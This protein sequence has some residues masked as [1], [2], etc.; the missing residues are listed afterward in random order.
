MNRYLKALGLATMVAFAF[1]AVAAASASAG[2]TTGMLTSD[3]PV[4]LEGTED[5]AGTNAFTAFGQEVQCP[6][7]H[8]TGHKANVTPHERLQGGETEVTIT[9][10]YTNCEDGE[11]GERSVNPNGC[12]YEFYDFTTTGDQVGT[13]GTYGL[14]A[15]ID[16]GETGKEIEVSGGTCVVRVPEQTELTGLHATNKAGAITIQG[17][18]HSITA[19]TCLGLTTHEAELHQAV[20]VE[21]ENK[22]GEATTISISH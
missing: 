19:N 20:K 17:T 1:S 16:C 12:D 15:H 7:S 18:I 6:E 4:T 9:P 11:G 21:G 10:E 8:Y 2:E 5:P 13:E 14:T 3:G 22:A